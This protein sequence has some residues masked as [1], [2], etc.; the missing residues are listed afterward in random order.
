MRRQQL[1]HIICLALLATCRH[2]TNTVNPNI[3]LPGAPKST[4]RASVSTGKVPPVPDSELVF[5]GSD[6]I[7]VPEGTEL[8]IKMT[9]PI[10]TSKN[11]SG[12]PFNATLAKALVV[13]TRLAVP[14]GAPV[15]GQLTDVSEA[16]EG[17][18]AEASLTVVEIMVNNRWFPLQTNLLTIQAGSN[19]TQSLDLSNTP[20]GSSAPDPLSTQII[21]IGGNSV[22]L[23][24]GYQIVFRLT[25]KA[26][27]EMSG[28]VR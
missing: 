20:P 8:L 10:D 5:L 22:R 24:A 25:Q 6:T 17:K 13:G 9:D 2:K 26:T 21:H 16:Q 12:D 15:H 4:E 19:G 3:I 11:K 23:P 27:V 28:A 7:A 14:I 18:G 1:I